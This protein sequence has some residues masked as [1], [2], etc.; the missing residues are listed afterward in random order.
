[1]IDAHIKKIIFWIFNKKWVTVQ[2]QR[3]SVPVVY[4]S[5]SSE[6]TQRKLKLRYVSTPFIELHYTCETN[7]KNK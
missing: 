6:D 7:L 2:V 5:H 1:M 3:F 4:W